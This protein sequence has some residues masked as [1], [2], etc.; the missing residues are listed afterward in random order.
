MNNVSYASALLKIGQEEKVRMIFCLFTNKWAPSLHKYE[1]VQSMSTFYFKTIKTIKNDA[2]SKTF[3]PYFLLLAQ[4][5]FLLTTVE[6]LP[7]RV[8]CMKHM[9][10]C[11]CCLHEWRI[12]PARRSHMIRARS[13]ER[14]NHL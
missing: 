3:L 11:C 4:C 1:S 7:K 13:A 9:N 8:T 10:C 14:E 2:D 6:K 5:I 12:I